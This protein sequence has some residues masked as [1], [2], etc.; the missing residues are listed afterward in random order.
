MKLLQELC[1]ITK[2][3]KKLNKKNMKLRASNVYDDP[4]RLHEMAASRKFSGCMQSKD[5]IALVRRFK[6]GDETYDLPDGRVYTMKK[7]VVK[8]DALAKDMLVMASYKSTNQGAQLYQVLGFTDD[9]D[10]YGEGGVKFDSV[11]Q[12]FAAKKV[13]SLKEL[14]E[15]QKKNKYGY[16]SYMVVADLEDKESGPWFYVFEGKWSRGSGAEPLSFT[17]VTL[18]RGKSGL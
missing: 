14:E 11:K 18:D 13:S 6:D 9:K 2:D 17:E 12:L 3:S 4:K 7:K 15:L 1:K 10:E 16:S 5:A 8:G